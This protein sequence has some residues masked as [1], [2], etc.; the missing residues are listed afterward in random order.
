MSLVSFVEKND[1]KKNPSKMGCGKFG[2][3]KPLIEKCFFENGPTR[4]SLL[5]CNFIFH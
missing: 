3:K 5:K 2:T 1:V 4:P